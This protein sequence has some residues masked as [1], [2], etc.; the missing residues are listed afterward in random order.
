M[1]QH[2]V[3]RTGTA[4]VNT[5]MHLALDLKVE[6][7]APLPDGPKIIAANHPTTTD[8][9]YIL[10][11][12]EEPTY[13]LVTEMAFKAPVFGSF[14]QA[15]GHIPVL[16][17]NGRPAFDEAVRR[18]EAGQT[19]AIFPEGALSPEIGGMSRPRT[20]AVRLAL[21]AG[22]P[23][24][25]VGIGLERARIH[26]VETTCGDMSETARWYLDGPYAL[27]VGEPLTFTGSLD[28]W[29]YVRD[30]SALL[31][32]RIGQ[33]AAESAYR[34]ENPRRVRPVPATDT[35]TFGHLRF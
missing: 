2:I 29:D 12:F 7:H 24:V 21:M 3:N 19:V 17:D 18:L 20:G 16:A 27:T 10:P 9:F 31:N 35:G 23:I 14:L 15:A 28:D 22:V 6:R 8:P 33:L 11:L 25:P 30:M 34:L 4:L 26:Y 5:F 32:N 1:I 13:I